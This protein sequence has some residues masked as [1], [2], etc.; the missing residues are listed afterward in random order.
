ML[1]R[2]S[3]PK[4]RRLTARTECSAFITYYW[5]GGRPRPFRIRDISEG[6]A[7]IESG[8]GW[9]VGTVLYLLLEP[10]DG[11]GHRPKDRFGLWAQI[12]RF[13]ADGIGVEFI[14][15]S[16]DERRKF[17]KFLGTM[18]GNQGLLR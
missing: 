18:K 15:T 17:H 1:F 12:V 8:E 5:T 3:K 6:G 16:L 9:G 11:N 4:D 14:M 10:S 7:F 13:E 2:R